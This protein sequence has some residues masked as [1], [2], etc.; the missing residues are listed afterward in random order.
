[1]AKPRNNYLDYAAY[2]GL[3]TFAMFVEMFDA[4]ANYGTA[5]LVSTILWRV[6]KRY[7]YRATEHIKRSFPDWSEAQ[8][9][10]V[11]RRSLDSLLCL[12]MEVLLTPRMITPARWRRHVELGN[13]AQGLRLL[14]ERK[15][16]LI[17]ITGHYGNWE[18]VGYTMAT[19]GFPGYAVARPLDN[20]YI[21]E[22]IMGIRERNGLRI[23]DKKGAT[24]DMDSILSSKGY[25]SFIADQDAGRK[26]MFVDFFGR[27]ASTYKSIALMAI[28]YNA[29]V[30]VGYGRRIGFDFRFEMGLERIIYPQDWADKDDPLRWITQEFTAGLEQII[31]KTPEQYLWAHRRWKHRPKGE[32]ESSDGVA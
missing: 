17:F 6:L 18:V 26:G 11:A 13:M 20:P 1:M 28:R 10:D 12:A 24:E 29:P 30:I 16:P 31:R 27:K 25:V 2:L 15:S 7:R 21:N 23:L 32:P 3:R 22:Y 9:R 8:V 5:R 19:L 14:V 4:K